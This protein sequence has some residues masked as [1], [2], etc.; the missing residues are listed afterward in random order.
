MTNTNM[1]WTCK[2]QRRSQ[3]SP[4]IHCSCF[5]GRRKE[6]SWHKFVSCLRLSILRRPRKST[7]SHHCEYKGWH[8]M[9]SVSLFVAAG[10]FSAIRLIHSFIPLF[11][12]HSKDDVRALFMIMQCPLFSGP[13]T[14]SIYAHL[15]RQILSLSNSDHHL[16]VHWLKTFVRSSL[17]N[18]FH[19]Y[20]IS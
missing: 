19:L 10:S 9:N 4:A 15:L 18:N 13:S 11:R 12:L 14:Y 7:Y 3:D 20:F 17:F 8:K 16:F 2:A 6:V 5:A 1:I